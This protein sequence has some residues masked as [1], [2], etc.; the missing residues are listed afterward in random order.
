[1]TDIVCP[2]CDHIKKSSDPKCGVCGNISEC[3]SVTDMDE[4]SDKGD[5]MTCPL[6]SFENREGT[7]FCEGCDTK[8]YDDVVVQYDEKYLERDTYVTSAV[9]EEQTNV[10]LV[11]DE[12]EG[13]APWREAIIFEDGSALRDVFQEK[14]FDPHELMKAKRPVLAKRDFFLQRT[15]F[16]YNSLGFAIVLRKHQM[17]KLAIELGVDL[18]TICVTWNYD[19]E[20]TPLGYAVHLQ[21]EPAILILLH[22]GAEWSTGQLCV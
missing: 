5:T 18:E 17:M 16:F 15:L 11:L 22:R 1:M 20:F 2:I 8:I 7:M 6:C 14:D 3:S 21:D 4:P 19:T 10:N 12:E 13:H 9:D